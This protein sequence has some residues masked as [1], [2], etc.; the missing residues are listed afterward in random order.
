MKSVNQ[1]RIWR[2]QKMERWVML[3]DWHNQYYMNG[4]TTKSNLYVQHNS[5]SKFQWPLH[6][7][8]SIW[9]FIWKHKRPQIGKAILSKKKNNGGITIPDFKLFYRITAIKIVRYWHKNRHKD[10]LNRTE[11][12]Q[13]NPH[14]YNH[15]IFD[16]GAQNICWRKD[17]F[18][19]KWC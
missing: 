13:I 7:E 8:K 4:Y 11:D 3:M 19:A 14:S 17:S 6:R 1:W 2:C 18:F 9:Q 16:K 15:L 10:Q 12:P 5:P